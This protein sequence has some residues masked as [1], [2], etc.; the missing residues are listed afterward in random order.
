[1]L[2]GLVKYQQDKPAESLAEF[3]RSAQLSRRPRASELVLVALDYVKLGDLANADKWMT[4]AVQEAPTSAGAWR[5]LGGIKYS[6]NRFTEA[7]EAYRK[8]LQLQPQDV[9]SEDGI[10]RSYEGLSRDKD[11]EAAYRTAFGWQAQATVKH[12]QPLLHLGA[13]LDREGQAEAAIPYLEAAE[14]LTPGDEDVHQELGESYERLNQLGKAQAELQQAIA[15]APQDSHLHWLL[16]TVFRKEGL[17]ADAEQG[18][19]HFP[20]LWARIPT[21]KPPDQAESPRQGAGKR[22]PLQTACIS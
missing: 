1:M 6:E 8:C 21:T 15:I 18:A 12:T 19:Q 7:I 17:T 3:R 2:L 16:A 9:L 11:A 10:G 5:Y 22:R 4:V 20:T 13:L 14:A